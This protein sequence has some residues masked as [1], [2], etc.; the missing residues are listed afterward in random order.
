MSKSVKNIV[1]GIV[2]ILLVAIDRISK[3]LVVQNLQGKENLVIIK[4]IFEL[5]FLANS[6]A[7]FSSFLGKRGFLITISTVIMLFCIFE[8]LRIPE[9]KRYAGLRITFLLLVSGAIGNLIDRVLTGFVVDFFY[10]VP[11]NF[12]RFNVADV[13]ITVAMVMLIV[14]FIFIYKD[15]ET[16]FLFKFKKN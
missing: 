11:I 6:G 7:A 9:T 5:E 16:D 3:V 2:C 4:N 13:Y 1:Y 12:P 15:E 8:F 10:F 14:Q